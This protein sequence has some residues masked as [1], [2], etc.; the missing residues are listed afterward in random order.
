MPRSVAEIQADIDR[1]KAQIAYNQKYSQGF[2]QPS[3]KVGWNSY[4]INNDRGLL[5]A[6]QARENA[7]KQ[8]QANADMQ[9]ELAGINKAAA[10]VDKTLADER[11]YNNARTRYD[12]AQRALKSIPKEN[13]DEREL[14]ERDLALA[15]HELD[16]YSKKLNIDMPETTETPK[17]NTEDQKPASR[18]ESKSVPVK[19]TDSKAIKRFKTKKDRDEHV[20]KLA[21]MDPNGQNTEI[22]EEIIRI[23]KLDTDE[24]KTARKA[25]YDKFKADLPK[26]KF[27]DISPSAMAKLLDENERFRTH[28]KEFGGK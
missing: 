18:E 22:Q 15:K 17:D 25:E 23:G 11:S 12:Y 7:W 1:V 19:L 14:A 16:Y 9:K 8:Q 4:I 20:A 5:D 10:D 27:G 21:A 24:E 26:T 6:Y 3:T 2:A 13:R 28:H